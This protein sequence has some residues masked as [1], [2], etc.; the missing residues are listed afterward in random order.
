MTHG[1]GLGPLKPNTVLFSYD[2]DRGSI[3][4]F[5][6]W[7][8]DVENSKKNGLILCYKDVIFVQEYTQY[9]W[10]KERKRKKIEII[11]QNESKQQIYFF[12][13]L[14][15]LLQNSEEFFHAEVVVSIVAAD[16]E[17]IESI[18]DYYEDFFSQKRCN[19]SLEITSLNEEKKIQGDL[20]ILSYT[21]FDD[22]IELAKKIAKKG[23]V[24]LL[25]H[26][27]E[28]IAFDQILD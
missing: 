8:Q 6:K 11:I 28:S 20:V 18:R 7:M 22:Q 19:F 12:F 24:T 13:V 4:H 14:A 1:Y 5:D 16:E 27:R 9:L 17:A 2:L 25:V 26:Q 15:T 10:I 3:H 21:F 23:G